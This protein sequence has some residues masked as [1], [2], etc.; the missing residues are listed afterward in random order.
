MTPAKLPLQ[1]VLE[2]RLTSALSVP[3]GTDPGVPGCEIG[4]DD[5]TEVSRNT[6]GV[7]TDLPHT[8]RCRAFSEVKAKQIAETAITDLTDRNNVPTPSGF[9]VLQVEATGSDMQR[10]R[11]TQGKDIF[12]EIVILTFRISRT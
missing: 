12:T 10:T 7:M 3:V 11:R 5:E 8:I 4:D 6:S 1:D 9:T 2:D